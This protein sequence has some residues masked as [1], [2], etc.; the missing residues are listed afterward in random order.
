MQSDNNQTQFD[1]VIKHKYK[2]NSTQTNNIQQHQANA[3]NINTIQQHQTQSI[4]IKQIKHNQTTIN[5]TYTESVKIKG[6]IGLLILV[7]IWSRIYAFCL[8]FWCNLAP[9]RARWWAF[10]PICGYFS[11]QNPLRSKGQ[12]AF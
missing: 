4:H 12:L 7:L 3:H 9:F 5:Y 8:S 1:K 10:G 11:S 2:H 6:P